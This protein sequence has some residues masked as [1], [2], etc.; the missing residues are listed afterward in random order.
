MKLEE[1]PFS[2]RRTHTSKCA[3]C[4]TI[5]TESISYELELKFQDGV[6]VYDKEY[7]RY[8]LFYRPKFYSAFAE[9]PQIIGE[10]L[11]L[12]SQNL[13]LLIEELSKIISSPL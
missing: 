3:C 4:E 10:H 12:G 9:V 11:G 1:L 8:L 7:K 13:E 6:D 2:L 5:K